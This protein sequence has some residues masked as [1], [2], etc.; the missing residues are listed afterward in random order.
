MHIISMINSLQTD[1]QD[2]LLEI[3]EIPNVF[4]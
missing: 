4:G 3:A 1:L 2:N